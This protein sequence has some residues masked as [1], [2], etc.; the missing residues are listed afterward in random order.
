VHPLQERP[1]V[2]AGPGSSSPPPPSRRAD[3]AVIVVSMDDADW[4]RP[5]LRSV[6][7][8]AGELELDVVVVENGA[9]SASAELLATEF[10]RA[11]LLESVN[12]GFAHANNR[13][14][15]TCDAR[16]LLFLNPD[17]EIVAGTLQALVAAIDELPGVGLVGVRHLTDGRIYPTMRRFPNALRSLGEALA[18]ERWPL[19]PAPLCERVLEMDRYEREVDCDWTVGAFMLARREA[20][21]GAG[22]LDERFFLYSEETDLCLRIRQAGWS[23][24]HMP[25]MTIV[26]HAGRGGLSPRMEAQNAYSRV[27]FA[28]KHF[29]PPHRAIHR[30]VLILG[31]AL[32]WSVAT[33]SGSRTR[34]RLASRTLAV[35]SGRSEPPFGHP[36]SV[37][38]EAPCGERG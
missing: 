24:R 29:S 20:L 2:G 14:L 8:Q 12:H 19:R 15:M 7:A 34:R 4:L 5:C 32:R 35:L 38:V 27:Q 13:A 3:L 26:H 17:T 25:D 36:P 30:L 11:R 37:A 22:I 23:V 16:H 33:L 1:T 31:G 18:V 10:P 9:T 28:R 21:A 6:F